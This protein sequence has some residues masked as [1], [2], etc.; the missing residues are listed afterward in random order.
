[1]HGDASRKLLDAGI[2]P[3]ALYGRM[4]RPSEA[5]MLAQCCSR[6]LAPEQAAP[7]QFGQHQRDEIGQSPRQHRRHDVESVGTVVEETRFELIHDLLRRAN[8]LPVAAR[9][10]TRW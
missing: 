2:L 4:L 1:M 9:P 5:E 6:I 8:Q 10:A 3:L 7:P